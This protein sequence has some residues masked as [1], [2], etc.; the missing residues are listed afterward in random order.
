MNHVFCHEVRLRQ[1]WNR[2]GCISWASDECG[3]KSRTLSPDC[4]PDVR[5]NHATR[6]GSD[7]ELLGNHVVHDLS[8]L[9]SAS[10][11][12]AELLLKKFAETGVFEGTLAAGI[13]RLICQGYHAI[14]QLLQMLQTFNDI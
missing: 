4:V 1:S 13:R 9:I 12:D 11:L 10:R 8:W 3:R 14:P 7:V 2:Q 6:G 5:S